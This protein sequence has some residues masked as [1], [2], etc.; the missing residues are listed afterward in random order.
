[1]GEIKACFK[2]MVEFGSFLDMCSEY[3]AFM[4]K[5]HFSAETDWEIMTTQYLC[6]SKVLTFMCYV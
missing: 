1:M 2:E 5:Q 6:T 3:Y 4:L